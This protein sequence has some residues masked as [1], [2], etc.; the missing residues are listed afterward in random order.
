MDRNA[1]ITVTLETILSAIFAIT[2]IG[3]TNLGWLKLL[4]AAY[5]VILLFEYAFLVIRSDEFDKPVVY[6]PTAVAQ[7]TVG[8][9]ST[10]FTDE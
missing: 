1:T 9:R 6:T 7:P 8:L 4:S 3:N 5:L 2:T 10:P